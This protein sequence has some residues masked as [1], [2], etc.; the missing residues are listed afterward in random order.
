M[1]TTLKQRN[2]CLIR[3]LVRQVDPDYPDHTGQFKGTWQVQFNGKCYALKRAMS[4]KELRKCGAH[5]SSEFNRDY[6]DM[7][8]EIVM[9]EEGDIRKDIINAYVGWAM[10]DGKLWGVQPWIESLDSENME[11]TEELRDAA[12]HFQN[13]NPSTDA[14]CHYYASEDDDDGTVYYWSGV[15]NVGVASDGS[16][17]MFDWGYGATRARSQRVMQNGKLMVRVDAEARVRG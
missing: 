4:Y 12:D 3:V 2:V 7:L 13:Y 6:D 15:H 14:S 16:I 11:C 8:S 5:P 1:L 9:Q 17:R 10:V